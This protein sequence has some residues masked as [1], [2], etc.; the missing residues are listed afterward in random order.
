MT[1]TKYFPHVA[2]QHSSP[3][4]CHLYVRLCDSVSQHVPDVKTCHLTRHF[5]YGMQ[6]VELAGNV[7]KIPAEFPL[8]QRSV[9]GRQRKQRV[10][11]F[12]VVPCFDEG[13]V[14]GLVRAMAV[15]A[16]SSICTCTVGASTSKASD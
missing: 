6:R 7:T 10:D 8:W 4:T 11:R 15:A 13:L 5:I 9:V 2:G 1:S 14:E 12:R 16:A 3:V